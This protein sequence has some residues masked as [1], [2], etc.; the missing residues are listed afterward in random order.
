MEIDN[1]RPLHAV[2]SSPPRP[3]VPAASPESPSLR[4]LFFVSKNLTDP[5]QSA[6]RVGEAASAAT[7][8]PLGLHASSEDVNFAGATGVGLET[9]VSVPARSCTSSSPATV[10]EASTASRSALPV[11]G[12]ASWRPDAPAGDSSLKR[13][14]SAPTRVL[15]SNDTLGKFRKDMKG[16]SKVEWSEGASDE[17]KHEE[18]Y[19]LASRLELHK[20]LLHFQIEQFQR[21]VNLQCRLTG[22][23]PLAQELVRVYFREY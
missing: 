21:I 15:P 10:V 22:S 3:D 7:D 14:G 19:D 20:K 17:E 9:R 2:D 23:N 8:T 4:A 11:P 13:N 1:S 5:V 18:S 16:I 6:Q 12:E